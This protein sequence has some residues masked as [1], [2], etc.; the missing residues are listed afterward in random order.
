MGFWIFMFCC[1]LI[2]PVTMLVIGIKFGKSAPKEINSLYGYR[3]AMSMK[4]K[5][6]WEFAHAYCGKVWRWI[7][8]IML[9]VSVV[10]SLHSMGMDEDGIGSVSGSLCVVQVVCMVGS[11]LPTELALKRKF[12]G[13]GR[14]KRQKG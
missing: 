11:I 12:D 13:Q 9:P 6:T 5:E 8:A 2:I 3:T 10:L 7:G 4:N 14:I 1:N